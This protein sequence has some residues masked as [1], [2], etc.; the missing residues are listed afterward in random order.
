M[1]IDAVKQ[2][3]IDRIRLYTRDRREMNK[4]I[5]REEATQ[6]EIELALDMS[7]DL[8]NDTPPVTPGR[9]TFQTI[10]SGRLIIHGAVIEL[11]TMSGLVFSRNKLT[12]N[13]QGVTVTV[14]DKAPEYSKWAEGLYSNYL[15]TA[16]KLKG[17]LN[18]QAC[19]SGIP[20]EQSTTDWWY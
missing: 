5:G 20:S 19:R 17:T 12:Y 6:D 10:P 7:V 11:L 16:M 15:R 8:F 9:Y 1:A 18:L 2:K 13:D 14:N 3:M 4:L